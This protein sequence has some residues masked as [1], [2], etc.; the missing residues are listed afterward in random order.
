MDI[1]NTKPLKHS[2]TDK[3]WRD[4]FLLGGIS[5]ASIAILIIIAISAYFIWPYTPGFTTVEET[6][7][8][9][10]NNGFAGLMSLDLFMIVA[11]L[12]TIP[13]FLALY[14]ALKHI[15]ESYALL[16][17]ILGLFACLLILTVRPIS[18]MFELSSKYFN[19]ET[20]ADKIRY[21][22]A[23]ETLTTLFNG[24]AW[25]LYMIM[26]GI[27]QLISCI[28]M[29]RTTFFTRKTAII[30]I[31][32]TIGMASVIPKIGVYINLLTT[33]LGT[34]WFVL[35]T[36]DLMNLYKTSK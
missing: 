34:V 1:N 29:L 3:K 2:Y 8:K 9:I 35:V 16:A 22:T 21:L 32:L 10:H 23:G 33:T 36:I 26:F 6:F 5:S 20:A 27:S 18:E 13:L 7:S 28:L 25:I 12:I 19:A 11:T 17:L 15:N 4:L 14:V 31:T 24:T 30:G